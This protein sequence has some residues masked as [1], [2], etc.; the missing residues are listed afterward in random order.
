MPSQKPKNFLLA[1]GLFILLMSSCSSPEMSSQNK[2][3]QSIDESH[4]ASSMLV[5]ERKL[6]NGLTVLLSPNSEEPR[7]YAEIITRAGSKHDPFSNTG[8][9]H[10]LEHLLFKGTQN[11]GTTDFEKEKPLLDQVTELYEERS[12]ESDQN[13]RNEIYEEINRISQSAAKLAIPNEMDRSYSDMGGKG[14]NAHTWHEETVYKVDLP[15]NRLEHWAKI[16]SDRF[17]NPVFRLFH[18]ELETVYEEKNRSIDNKDRLLN[19]EVNKLLFKTHPYGQQATLGTIEHLKNPSILAIENFYAQHY[20][21]ENMAICISGDIDPD[22]CFSIIEKYFSNWENQET[23]RPEPSWEEKPLQGREF[24][25]VQYLGEEQVLLAFRTAPRFHQD[26]P[27]LRL[28]DMILDNAVA[29]L[30]N[31][32][33]TEKQAVRSAGCFPQNYNDEGAHYFY[34]IPKDGQSMEEVEQLLLTQIAKVKNGEFEDWILPAVINDFKKTKK[35]DRESNAKRV[36]LLRD[37]FLAF[38]D[39]KTMDQSI[40]ELEKVTK[41][42]IIRTARKYYGND[43]VVGFRIDAQHQL[44]SIEKPKIDPLKIDPDKESD[45]MKAVESLGFEPFNPKFLVEGKDFSTEKITDGVTLIHATNPLNDLFTMEVRMETGYD[46]ES[47]LPYLK[48]M[49]DRSGAGPLS[50]EELKIEWYK[51]ASDFNFAVREHL[52]AFSISGLDENFITSLDLTHQLLTEPN[53]S[54]KTWE[55]TKRI[56]ISERDDEQKNPNALSNALAHFHR[57]GKESRYLK[58]P[59]DEQLNATTVQDAKSMISQALQVERTVLYFG[60]R[61]PDEV[62]ATILDG[63]LGQSPTTPTPPHKPNRSFAADSN[64][65]YFFQKEMAQAQVRLEFATGTYDESK[66]PLAQV[67]NEYFGGGMAGLVFQELREAR[68]LA[69]SAWAHY[70][71]P[72]RKR[73]ENILVGAIGCQADKTLE[74]VTAFVEL[75]DNMPINQTRWESAHSAILSTY[76][77][78]PI[79]SRS[80]PSYAYDVRTLGLNGD[81]RENRYKA[82]KEADISSLRKFYGEE[83][84]PKNILISI[85]GDSAKIDLG[86]LKEFGP[87]T[88][89]KVGELFNR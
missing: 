10:Y 28:I 34:G 24:V 38:V 6:E 63:F 78:N 65:V 30:I 33:L 73:E 70:F 40:E 88:Q 44:P 3:S 77:T 26:Y 48:R 16:E 82:L 15:A 81:P 87:L 53:L 51:L 75:L 55:E 37:S 36:E 68:A 41:E 67:F 39:W 20:V 18:T 9:A 50:S 22:A 19:R 11:F 46:H 5:L 45:F 80:R 74:A 83:I 2:K 12:K 32:N 21:P 84:K 29:G 47:M 72:S 1:K 43:Y 57:Y 61:S 86:K 7:F 79:G 59:S 42:E 25:Q 64:Q 69:Y 54:E 66:A 76:R 13:R 14:I 31:L 52:S 60:P 58:R 23:L 35:E 27:A 56:I 4:Q 8:L 89:V 71:T 62:K 49:L 85:V 17:A